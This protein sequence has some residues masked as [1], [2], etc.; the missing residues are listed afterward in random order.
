V[1][2]LNCQI[3]KSKN[4]LLMNPKYSCKQEK[5]APKRLHKRATGLC[6]DKYSQL[7]SLSSDAPPSAPLIDSKSQKKWQNNQ[8]KRIKEPSSPCSEILLQAEVNHYTEVAPTSTI[9]TEIV[10]TNSN[11]PGP[12]FLP[13]ARSAVRRLEVE[14]KARIVDSRNHPLLSPKDACKQE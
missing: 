4:H 14:R 9:M 10:S 8:S 7:R 3:S 5:I 6:R 2:R 13:T 1:K 11:P 12:L